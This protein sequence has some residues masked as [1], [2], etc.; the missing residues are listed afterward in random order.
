MPKRSPR[1][2]LF[3][4]R[5]IKIKSTPATLI[6]YFQAESAEQGHPTGDCRAR[7]QRPAYAIQTGRTEGPGD[8]LV[9]F[10]V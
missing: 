3:E 9:S 8:R 2:K 7:D 10:L 4:W 5:V 1:E 6:G